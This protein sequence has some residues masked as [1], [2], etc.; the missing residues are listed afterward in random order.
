MERALSKK[1][2]D[3]LVIMITGR[4]PR[5]IAEVVQEKPL[6]LKVEERGLFA[7]LRGDDFIVVE[8]DS[9]V[10]Q[11][12]DQGKLDA[13]LREAKERGHPFL[14]GLKQFGVNDGKMHEM[15]PVAE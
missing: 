4:I 12:E 3:L 10:L 7:S 5:Y 15:L 2:G 1:P 8:F 14:S 9:M 13:M 6:R 11:G